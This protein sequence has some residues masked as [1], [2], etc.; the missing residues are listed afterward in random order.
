MSTFLGNLVSSARICSYTDSCHS[1]THTYFLLALNSTASL[2]FEVVVL[3]TT[4]FLWVPDCYKV[5]SAVLGL[6]WWLR[7]GSVCMQ[8]GSP[9]FYPWVGKIPWRRK[10]HP[11]PVLLPEK[12]HGWR[13]LVGYSPWGHKESDMTEQF[14]YA[15][16]GKK[17]Q[18]IKFSLEKRNRWQRTRML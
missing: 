14:H 13:N 7:Q 12:F 3:E 15:V 18:G 16:L 2:I 9:G 17:T 8:C 5:T 11:T 4:P 10:W 6:P 1:K